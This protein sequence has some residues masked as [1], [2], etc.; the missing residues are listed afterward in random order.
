MRLS[1]EFGVRAPC[2]VVLTHQLQHW[3]MGDSNT[4]DF[5]QSENRILRGMTSFAYNESV[6]SYR[7]GRCLIH[8]MSSAQKLHAGKPSVPL[9]ITAF[10]LVL[11]SVVV[12]AIQL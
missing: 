12:S 9:M 10:D 1:N 6:S 11:S 5:D 7:I 3:I 4:L 2:D 8:H